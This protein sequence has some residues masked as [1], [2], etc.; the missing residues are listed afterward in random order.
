MASSGE[1][2]PCVSGSPSPSPLPVKYKVFA[3]PSHAAEIR[4]KRKPP[5]SHDKTA[6]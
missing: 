2:V 4:V 1:N 5:L 3:N 6:I